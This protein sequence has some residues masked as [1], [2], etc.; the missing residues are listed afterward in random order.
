MTYEYRGW[1]IDAT[2]EF[3][4]GQF[5]AHARII[6]ASPDDDT[7]TE[8]VAIHREDAAIHQFDNGFRQVGLHGKVLDLN[9]AR[10][11][12]DR[13]QQAINTDV[14]GLTE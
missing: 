10:N 6:Q 7:D 14:L 5:F 3:A 8:M 2:P 1:V 11:A 12:T 4:L 13:Q 9:C